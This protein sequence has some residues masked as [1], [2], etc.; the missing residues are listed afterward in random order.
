MPAGRPKEPAEGASRTAVR[1]QIRVKP[2]ASRTAVGGE[3]GAPV[4]GRSDGGDAVSGGGGHD[5]GR[6][7]TDGAVRDGDGGG[8]SLVVAVQERAVD[9]KATAAALTALAKALRIAPRTVRLV[10]GATSRDKIVAVDDPPSD[11]AARV[12]ALRGAR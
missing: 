5:G 9:G 11:L 4:A 10:S 12:Q 6:A 2:G 3:Y 7:D 8:G 1:I